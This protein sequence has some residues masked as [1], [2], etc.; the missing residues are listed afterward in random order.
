MQIA[1]EAPASYRSSSHRPG[2]VTL[3]TTAWRDV[4]SRR[5][6]IRYLVAADIKK[7][8]SDTLLGNLWWLL[9][10]LMAMAVYV[11]VMSVIFQRS[12]PDFALYLLAAVIPF[13]WF[14]QSISDAVGSVVRNERL[15][16][17]IQ[18]PK[19]VLPIS[20]S[21]S[22][23]V[24]FAFGMLL[25]LGLSII[26]AGGAHLSLMLLWVPVIAVVQFVLILGLSFLVS[27]FTVFYRDVGIV[28][29]H[30]MRLLFFMSPILWSFDAGTG[31]GDQL[32]TAVGET[33][34]QLLSLNPVAILLSA[35]R[36][37][38]YGTVAETPEGELTWLPPTAPDTGQLL[39]LF[40]ISIALLVIGTWF[41][42]RLEPAFAKVL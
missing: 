30:L 4:M 15:I 31:R 10:P 13:K 29:G 18:F 34:Y 21:A 9:D 26:T 42:K 8:G 16:K 20:G 32:R 40:V 14:T 39:V 5:R 2:P 7:K 17:Q 41:F 12:Q 33:G 1:N 28:I 23:V 3:I 24:S 11:F 38:I 35:Y 6:L 27:A 19:I 25:L 37:V 36:H 22:E